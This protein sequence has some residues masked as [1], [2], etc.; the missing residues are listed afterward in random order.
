MLSPCPQ[1]SKKL[2]GSSQFV[3]VELCEEIKIDTLV[4]AN[5]EFFSNMFKKFTV[6]AAKQLTG[7]ENDWTQLGV[8]RARNIRGQQVFRIPSATTLRR[9]LPLRPHRF[10]RALRQ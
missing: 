10:S 4:L 6:T 3:I 7:R 1:P 8:F 9:L 2:K 5:Y